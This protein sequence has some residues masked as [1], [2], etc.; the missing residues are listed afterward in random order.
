MLFFADSALA[1]SGD[2]VFQETFDTEEDFQKWTIVDVNGGRTWEFLNGKAAYMLDYQ[3]GLPGDDWYISPE[4]QLEADKVYELKFYL[5]VLSKTENLRVLLGTSTDIASFTK[6]LGDFQGVVKSD[7]G[8]KTL[9]LYANETGKY[10]IAFYAYSEPNQHRVEIDNVFITEKTL[11]TVPGAATSLAVTPAEQGE[12]KADLAFNAPAL[13]A[14]DQTLADLTAVDIYRNNSESPVHTFA[15]PT[16][17]AA[18]TWTDEAPVNGY[19]IYKVVARNAA[20][21]GEAVEIKAFVGKDLPVAVG[22]VVAKLNSDMSITVAWDAPTTSVNGGYVDFN[23]LSYNVYRNSE[24]SGYVAEGIADRTYTDNVPVAS[25]QVSVSYDVYPVYEGV[26]GEKATSGSVS[27]GKPL[28]LPYSESFA[29]GKMNNWTVDGEVNDFE[30]DATDGLFDDWTGEYIVEAQ[31]HDSGLLQASSQYADYGEQSRVVSPMLNLASVKAPVLTFWFHYGRSQWYDPEW[32]GEVNDNI[33]VQIAFDGGDWQDVENAQ[34][35]LNDKTDQWV[36]CEV[37]LPKQACNF[38]N[39]AFLATAESE[40]GARRDLM[41]DHITVGEAKYGKDLSLQTLAVDKKRAAVGE[42]VSYTAAVYNRGAEPAT[43]YS[44]RFVRDGE[45][46]EEVP[47][48]E[49]AVAKT[50]AVTLTTTATLDDAQDEEHVWTAE[51]VFASDEFPDNNASEKLVT[52]VRKPDVPTVENLTGD[53]GETFIRLSWDAASS[54]EPTPHGD[55]ITVTDDFE[56]YTPFIIDNIGDWTVYDGDKATTLSTPRIPNDYDHRGEPMAYQVFNIYDA[57]VWTEETQD[58]AFAPHS[59]SQYLACPSVNWPE[60][61]D[62]WLIT[63]RLDGRSQTVRFWSKAATFDS[64]WINV[65]VS[66]TDNH[67]D[68]FTKLNNDEQIYVN[69]SWREYE[70]DVPEGTKYFAVR[71]VRRSVFLFIDDFT[72]NKWDESADAR[73]LLGYNV[74]RD[75]QLVGYVSAPQTTFEDTTVSEGETHTYAV[76]AV[77]AEGESDYSDAVTVVASA[78]S[79]VGAQSPAVKEAYTLDGRR[80]ASLQRGVNIV[81]TTDGKTRKVLVK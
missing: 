74:Y 62:D 29:W 7:S 52:S 14:D 49:V 40:Q 37:S 42:S 19:N 38:A 75:G 72:Y 10:R 46:V 48:E 1:D 65:Y 45:L 30:W 69:D 35:F 8:D 58:H 23:A 5:G 2:V 79:S 80:A 32:D 9:K 4:F 71:C 56:E 20:G 17:G 22:N 41:I 77:Y 16:V 28:D 43:D 60:E 13:T 61:N 24:S 31:D 18:L 36:E 81:R 76:T 63:P 53:A 70:F 33:Q 57:G 51:I 67:H 34:F 11:K 12:L 27:T 15:N 39:I 68:S 25:G 26:E 55:P 21:E 44:V 78:I 73:T 50:V 6:V 47:G 59:G 3:T 54:V 64:E 66:S